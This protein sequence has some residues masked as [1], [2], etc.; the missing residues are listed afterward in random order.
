[1]YDFEARL[2]VDHV[3]AAIRLIRAGNPPRGQLLKLA[4]AAVGE[5]GAL[6]EKGPIFSVMEDSEVDIESAIAQLEALEFSAESA[7]PNFDITPFIPIIIAVIQWI[8]NRR[9]G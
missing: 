3:L 4:G 6:L 2:P 8:I 5:V 9:N 1:M 7:E